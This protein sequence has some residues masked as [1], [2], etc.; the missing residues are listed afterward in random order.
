MSTK[1]VCRCATKSFQSLN[2]LFNK[3]GAYGIEWTFTKKPI[4][5]CKKRELTSWLEENNLSIN[6][7]RLGSKAYECEEF[8]AFY[9]NE[10]GENK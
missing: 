7:I 9:P 8:I 1:M 2:I 10:K 3:I 4:F 6:S 5:Q